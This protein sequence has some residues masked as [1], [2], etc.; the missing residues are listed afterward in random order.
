MSRE[1]RQLD[2][3]EYVIGTM[4]PAERHAFEFSI[5]SDEQT[6]ED[7]AFWERAFS[8]LTATISPQ[9]VP[10]AVWEAISRQLDEATGTAAAP[11]VPS[12][13]QASRPAERP[14]SSRARPVAAND[15]AIDDLRRS[16]SRWRMGAIAATIA[17]LVL[18]ASLLSQDPARSPGDRI[19][20]GES[21]GQYIAVVNANGDQPSL[22]VN[23]DTKSGEVTVRSLGIQ[24][25]DG[26]SLEVWYVPQGET[27]ISVGL[28]SEGEIDL[29]NVT[30]ADGDLLAISLEPP[31]GSPTGT[32]TGPIIYTGKLVENVD[33]EASR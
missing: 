4:T 17:V 18:G 21:S 31:G 5:E 7:V 20:S 26:K 9:V 14:A 28:V 33:A 3:A 8:V 22:V 11:E 23:V 15:N 25:P 10:A 30:V 27:P 2:A 6:R 1:E 16:R 13:S 12:D 32:A 19:A 24:K 29:S